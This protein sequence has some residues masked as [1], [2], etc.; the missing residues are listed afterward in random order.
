MLSE[1]LEII[2]ARRSG[3][4]RPGTNVRL[5]FAATGRVRSDP[6]LLDDFIQRVLLFAENAPVFISGKSSLHDFGDDAVV[7]G[8]S[9]RVK[10]VY[11]IGVSDIAAGSGNIAEIL[12]RIGRAGDFQPRAVTIRGRS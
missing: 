3:M 2:R 12:E 9:A 7:Q 8:L 4:P 1:N 10:D 11:S 5:Q 6:S